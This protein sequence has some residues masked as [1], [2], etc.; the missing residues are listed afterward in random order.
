MCILFARLPLLED[1]D[2]HTGTEKTACIMYAA[3][4]LYRL[5]MFKTPP[6]DSRKT[7]R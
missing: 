4:V 3:M 5:Q 2:N 7:Y 6:E 1:G